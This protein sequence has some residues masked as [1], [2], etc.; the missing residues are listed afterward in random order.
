MV[1]RI[2][3]QGN[4]KK[5]F[6]VPVHPETGIAR[7]MG[8]AFDD[9]WNIYLCDNQGWSGKPELQYKGRKYEAHSWVYLLLQE[10]QKWPAR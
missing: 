5:W 9:E 4:V 3:K 1:V 10:R 6:E 8:I 2:D 7:N